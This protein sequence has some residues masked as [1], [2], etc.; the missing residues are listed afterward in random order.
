[1]SGHTPVL[2]ASGDRIY[3]ETPEDGLIARVYGDHELAMKMAAA[4][5]M[6]EALKLL[7]KLRSY[8]TLEEAAREYPHGKEDVADEIAAF[9][10]IRAAIAKAEGAS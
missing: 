2:T 9:D 10:A 7:L 3:G 4:L 8:Q 6:L 1:M 5:E